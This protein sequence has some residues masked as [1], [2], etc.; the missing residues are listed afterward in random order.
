MHHASQ[1]AERARHDHVDRR[2]P[3][4]LGSHAAF[5][6]FTTADRRRAFVTSPGDDAT[7]EIDP[8]TLRVVRTHPV[9]GY[10]GAVSADGRLF[11]LGSQDGSV[12]LLDLDTGDIRRFR[13]RHEGGGMRLLTFTDDGRALASAARELATAVRRGAL[14]RL[15][16]ERAD[17]EHILGRKDPLREALE[18]AGFIV[19][20]RGLRLRG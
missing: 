1:P 11:A 4:E 17:G 8:A 16:V 9:G 6:L 3:L 5:N 12:R 10:A 14:G 15:T 19:T 7:W 18:A 13:G 20:P 2:P